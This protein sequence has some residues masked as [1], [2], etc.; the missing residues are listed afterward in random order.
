M[1]DLISSRVR[2]SRYDIF[3]RALSSSVE[4]MDVAEEDRD[5]ALFLGF[6]RPKVDKRGSEASKIGEGSC[7][8]SVLEPSSWHSDSAASAS[9]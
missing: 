8:V 1:S 4:E 3:G 2:A 5:V 7:E 6:L 9:C